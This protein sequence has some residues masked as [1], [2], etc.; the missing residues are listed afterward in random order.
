MVSI[1]S[2]LVAPKLHQNFDREGGS[3]GDNQLFID[4]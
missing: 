3:V 2:M 1:V 4:V